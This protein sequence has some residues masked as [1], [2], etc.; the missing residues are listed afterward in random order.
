MLCYFQVYSTMIPT[1]VF[2]PGESHGQRSQAGYSPSG[3]KVGHELSSWVLGNLFNQWVLTLKTGLGLKTPQR[4]MP[5]FEMTVLILPSMI[6][7]ASINLN[8]CVPSC[9]RCVWLFEILWTVVHQAPQSMASSRQETGVGCHYLLQGIFPTQ[10]LNL[11]LISLALAG[12][13]PTLLFWEPLGKSYSAILAV[14][15]L[16]SC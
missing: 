13:S 5:A 1:P 6:S 8:T 15:Y 7:S 3:C 10:G 16:V 2:L 12:R 4:I 11:C 14:R 9:F